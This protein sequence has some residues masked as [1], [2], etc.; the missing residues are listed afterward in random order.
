MFPEVY[1]V[2]SALVS[3]AHLNLAAIA[4]VHPKICQQKLFFRRTVLE[5]IFPPNCKPYFTLSSQKDL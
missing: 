1:C 3:R 5:D 4:D 2:Y